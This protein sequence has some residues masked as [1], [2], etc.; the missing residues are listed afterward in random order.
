MGHG[1]AV[2]AVL[3]G[4]WVAAIL[5]LILVLRLTV[6]GATEPTRTIAM[7]L[8]VIGMALFPAAPAM[9]AWLSAYYG[10]VAAARILG[11]LAVIAAVVGVW[12]VQFATTT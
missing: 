7:V 2:V 4:G 3:V 8:F 10:W 6:W 9:A 5:L 11:V 1:I 12:T